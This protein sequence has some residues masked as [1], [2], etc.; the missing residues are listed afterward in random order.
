MTLSTCLLPSTPPYKAQLQ[1]ILD[2][3]NAKSAKI[4]EIESYCFATSNTRIKLLITVYSPLR[5]ASSEFANVS[6][7]L[8]MQSETLPMEL[9]LGIP[10]R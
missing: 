4:I 6:F 3:Q 10:V 1:S 2:Q 9:L 8:E 5:I 7:R